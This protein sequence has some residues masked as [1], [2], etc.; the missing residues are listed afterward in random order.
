[1]CARGNARCSPITQRWRSREVTVAT[2]CCGMCATAHVKQ[3]VCIT[4]RSDCP[5]LAACRHCYSRGRPD[6]IT[7]NETHTQRHTHRI[8]NTGDC[9]RKTQPT[10]GVS[11]DSKHDSS[12]CSRN[13]MHFWQVHAGIEIRRV[14]KMLHGGS[15]LAYCSCL[16]VAL[17]RN[18]LCI[19]TIDAPCNWGRL[20]FILLRE[21]AYYYN[22]KLRGGKQAVF[23]MLRSICEV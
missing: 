5:H 19:I 14:W 18:T 6:P 21:Q 3:V 17:S 7:N 1:M 22:Q 23:A 13:E 12:M 4:S 20:F 8:C 16:P 11:S 2:I 15:A 10:A 9:D